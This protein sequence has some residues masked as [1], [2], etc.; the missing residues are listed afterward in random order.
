M[1]AKDLPEPHVEEILLRQARYVLRDLHQ[2]HP[3]C[4]YGKMAAACERVADYISQNA[5]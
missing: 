3:D 2:K 5:S 1:C 4:G